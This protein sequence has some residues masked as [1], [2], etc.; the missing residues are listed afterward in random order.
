M[1]PIIV[2]STA[3]CTKLPAKIDSDMVWASFK[4]YDAV[5]NLNSLQDPSSPCISLH[6][7][8]KINLSS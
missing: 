7:F 4:T 8:Q 6:N 3:L 5:F 2:K 1:S